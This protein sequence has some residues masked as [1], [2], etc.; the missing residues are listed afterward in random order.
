M[1]EAPMGTRFGNNEQQSTKF[2]IMV[3]LYILKGQAQQEEAGGKVEVTRERK[4]E[5]QLPPNREREKKAE[6]VIVF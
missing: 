4:T 2:Y 5:D 3:V 6:R 1:A